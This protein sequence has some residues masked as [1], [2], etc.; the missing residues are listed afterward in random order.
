MDLE[1]KDYV[2]DELINFPNLIEFTDSVG[3]ID[4]LKELN[5]E[6]FKNT[7]NKINFDTYTRVVI[8]NK[9]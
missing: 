9:K 3:D 8:T 6:E 1:R 5:F 4:T 2:I 7:I